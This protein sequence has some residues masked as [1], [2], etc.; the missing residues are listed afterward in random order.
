MYSLE[1]PRVYG[2]PKSTACFKLTPEDFHVNE[3]FADGFS[4][5][6][7]HIILRIEKKGVTTEEV[8][9]SLSRLINLPAKLISYAGLKNRQALTTQ[10]FQYSC[11]RK[12]D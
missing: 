10:W 7:E 4:G 8:V 2:N 3:F 1:W 11:P 9:K 6:G 5:E 12:G